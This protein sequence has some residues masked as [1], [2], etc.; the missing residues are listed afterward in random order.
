MIGAT[1][2]RTEG[3]DLVMERVFDAP[4]ALVWKAFTEPERIARW[5]GPHGTTTT[6]VEMDVRPGGIWRYI[7]H[8]PDGD[9]PFT[10]Q[11]REVVPPERLVYTFVYDVEGLRDQ[12]AIVTE[13]L[14]ALESRTRLTSRTR[15]PSVE[16][17]EGAAAAGMA[18]GAMQTWDRLAAEL[19]DMVRDAAEGPESRG[20]RRGR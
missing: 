13:T 5:W 18:E 12:V 9:D 17:L 4:R 1:A 2:V 16:A 10:G 7:N 8:T 14:T 19:A 20:Y 11:Y 6:I 15:F 3:A